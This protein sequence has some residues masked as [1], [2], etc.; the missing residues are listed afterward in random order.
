MIINTIGVLGFWGFGVLGSRAESS[1]S[2]DRAAFPSKPSAGRWESDA[3]PST[4]SNC[5]GRNQ[6]KG[7]S[8]CPEARHQTG[9]TAAHS[10]RVAE[11]GRRRRPITPA[12]PSGKIYSA[13]F[14]QMCMDLYSAPILLPT[15]SSHQ[16]AFVT[17][18]NLL[19]LPLVQPGVNAKPIL[20]LSRCLRHR[21]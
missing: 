11:Q 21:C 15:D 16:P 12:I 13:C 3:L 5:T 1:G 20:Q 7:P 17:G 8:I 18:F 14:L 2:T 4:S 10:V 6:R 19:A 9:L